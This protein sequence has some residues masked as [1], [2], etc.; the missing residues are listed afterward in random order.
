MTIFPCRSALPQA[1]P[2]KKR[3]KI[4]TMIFLCRRVLLQGAH[5]R[6]ASITERHLL[7]RRSCSTFAITSAPSRAAASAWFPNKRSGGSTT[8]SRFPKH[9]L[10]STSSGLPSTAATATTRLSRRPARRR[11]P[12]PASWLSSSTPW[13]RPPSRR[14]HARTCWAIQQHAPSASG[15]L[16]ATRPCTYRAKLR[17]P[18]SHAHCAIISTSHPIR[19]CNSVGN[20]VCRGTAA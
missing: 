3:K 4:Q 8:A 6:S 9:V 15:I 19:G 16:P 18:C 7:M 11:L 20:S 1:C 10:C 2:E 12:S 14:L 13:F 5:V 17:I